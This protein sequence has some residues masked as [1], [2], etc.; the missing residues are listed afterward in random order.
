M[1][2]KQAQLAPH[3][4]SRAKSPHPLYNAEED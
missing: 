2:N 3:D 4:T 1:A